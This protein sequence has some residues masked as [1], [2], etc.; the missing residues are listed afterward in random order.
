MS[1]DVLFDCVVE[2]INF[3]FNNYWNR[4]SSFA[5]AHNI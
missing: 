2:L 1:D 4:N 5:K 3:N